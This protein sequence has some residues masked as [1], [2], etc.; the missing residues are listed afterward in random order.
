MTD[1]ERRTAVTQF[2]ADWNGRDIDL[3]RGY[4]QS[5]VA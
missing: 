4:K 3:P 1:V 5:D 2:A